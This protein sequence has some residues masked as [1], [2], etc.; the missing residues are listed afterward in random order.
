MKGMEEDG[1]GG[2]IGREENEIKDGNG[3]IKGGG[4]IEI[5]GGRKMEWEENGRKDEKGRKMRR[6]DEKRK[7]GRLE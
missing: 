4:R 7:E 1:M 6:D 3:K 2:G 5:D